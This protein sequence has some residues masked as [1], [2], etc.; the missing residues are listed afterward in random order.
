MNMLIN[1]LSLEPV[2]S[3]NKA[4]LYYSIENKTV[5]LY[6]DKKNVR[7]LLHWSTYGQPK[8]VSC[9]SFEGVTLKLSVILEPY[10]KELLKV[11]SYAQIKDFSKKVLESL[12]IEPTVKV[13][14]TR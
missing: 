10:D 7:V 13:R 9:L 8:V 2:T 3:L 6:D 4:D 14:L 11:G 1:N 12:A 5:H